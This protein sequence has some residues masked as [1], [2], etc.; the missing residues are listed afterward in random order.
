MR[1]DFDCCCFV[2]KFDDFSYIILLMYAYDM[3]IVGSSLGKINRVKQQLAKYFEMKSLGAAKQILGMRIT[4][5]IDGV[6]FLSQ[7][8]YVKKVL[9]RFGMSGAK[10]VKRL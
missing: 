4:R 5:D 7:A 8:E 2:K 9:A 1:S 6:I 3:L 10:P